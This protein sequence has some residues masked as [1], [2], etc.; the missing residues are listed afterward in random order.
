MKY[1]DWFLLFV[2]RS[3]SFTSNKIVHKFGLRTQDTEDDAREY[4]ATPAALLIFFQL[5]QDAGQT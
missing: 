1:R 2:T 3:L 4:M 5:H